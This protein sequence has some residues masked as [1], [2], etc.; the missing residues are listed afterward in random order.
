M[1]FP[2]LIEGLVR[3]LEVECHCAEASS[4][5]VE[6]EVLVVLMVTF[7]RFLNGGRNLARSLLTVFAFFESN[8][9]FF[10]TYTPWLLFLRSNNFSPLLNSQL[11]L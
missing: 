1:G 11:T 4:L 7:G 2:L 10:G 5:E 8:T 9:R 6:V 3:S